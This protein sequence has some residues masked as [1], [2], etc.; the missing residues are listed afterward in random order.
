MKRGFLIL[1]RFDTFRYTPLHIRRV[2]AKK[3]GGNADILRIF[4]EENSCYPRKRERDEA[5][6]SRILH[7]RFHNSDVFATQR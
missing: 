2:P 4:I 7:G 1:K 3:D 6:F 5:I